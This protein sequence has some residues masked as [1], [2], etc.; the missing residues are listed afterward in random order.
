MHIRSI[1]CLV[2]AI[3]IATP[4]LA[5]SLA[6]EEFTASRDMACVL[7]QEQL[8]L[9]DEEEYGNK[10]HRVL[11][12][13]DD[14]E[15]DTILAKALGY[16]DGLMFAIGDEKNVEAVEHRLQDFVASSLCAKNNRAITVPL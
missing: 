10:T 1:L 5:L 9:L 7:A 4:A 2:A 13:F 11:D 8:G 3:V 15:R 14:S 6:P 16:Y 12:G